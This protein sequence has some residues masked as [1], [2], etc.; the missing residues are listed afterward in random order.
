MR[1]NHG[2]YMILAK[3]VQ[4]PQKIS[5]ALVQQPIPFFHQKIKKTLVFKIFNHLQAHCGLKG[6]PETRNP[7]PTR[8]NRAVNFK[9]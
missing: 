2:S 8:P 3:N 9:T 4:F 5:C 6:P 1:I 7:G